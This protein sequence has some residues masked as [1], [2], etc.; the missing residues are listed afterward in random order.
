MAATNGVSARPTLSRALADARATTRGAGSIEWPGADVLDLPE[1][2]MQFGTGALLRGL[3]DFFIDEANAR[4][5]FGGRIVMVGS[6]GSGRDRRINEQ[7]GLYT[8][9]VQ[10]LVDGAARRDCRVV[11]SVSRAL[12]ATSEWHEVLRAAESPSLDLIFS[13]T[14]EVGIVLDE[15]DAR[16]G[17]GEGAPRSFPAKLA[18]VLLHRARHFRYQPARA[19]VVV[20]C[21]LIEDNGDRLR[22]IV[23]ALSE[24]WAL[25]PE[26]TPWLNRVVF[27][28]T[29]VDR[30]VPGAPSGEQAREL[31]EALGYDDAMLTVCEPYRLFAIQGD[32]GLRARLGFAGADPGI[33]VA[34]DIAPYRERKVRLLNGAHTS[35]VSLAILAGCTTV[36][37]AVEHPVIGAFLRTVLF[38]E[39]VPSV[40]VPGAASFAAEVMSRFANPY[41]NHALWDITLQGTAKFRVRLVPTILAYARRTGQAPRALALGFAAYLAFQ[42][43]ELQ[44]ERRAAGATVPPDAASETMRALW[45]STSDT[46]LSGFVRDV[47]TRD[48][49][50]GTDL[51]AVPGF[52]DAVSEQLGRIRQE[53]AVAAMAAL[54]G[55]SV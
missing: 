35:F 25:E 5:E 16:A 50:W 12:A 10:G 4:G 49:L 8:L 46:D 20:P 3:V 36:R 7:D 23:T 37:E 22:A 13:N 33:I 14:T 41:L 44:A 2:A 9:V 48:D 47:C 21:E 54:V 55:A 34:E 31:G 51:S 11:A 43:G 19:P 42:R 6:T 45:S 24:R 1:R 26:F 40:V 52:V 28:N 17:A 30:I 27:C 53:G 38:D 29:L 15:D 32:D 39:I 18:S